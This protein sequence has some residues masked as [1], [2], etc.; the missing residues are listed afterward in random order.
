MLLSSGRW[1]GQWSIGSVSNPGGTVW[2]HVWGSESPD[3]APVSTVKGNDMGYVKDAG[4]A[5]CYPEV[6]HTPKIEKFIRELGQDRKPVFLSEYGV[7]SM[8]DVIGEWHHF[9]QAGVRPDLEDNAWVKRQSEALAADWKR[10]GFDDV[11]PFPEDLLRESQRLTARQR[12]LGFDLIRSNPDLCGFNLT[13]MLDHG[14]C[15][16]GLWTLWREWKPSTFDAVSDGWS[17]LRWCLFANPMNAYTG[18]KLTLE[19]VLA[20]EEV[21]KPGEY[22]ARFRLFG[23]AGPVWEKSA[24]V[25]IPESDPLAIPVIRETFQLEGPPGR[26]TFAADLESGAPTGGRLEFQ[27]TDPVALPKLAGSAVAWGLDVS[28]QEWLG[29]RGLTIQPLA[30]TVPADAQ[31]ILVGTPTNA[32]DPK[33][34]E[35]L[36][37]RMTGGATV[38]FLRP[39]LFLENKQAMAW[40]PLKNPGRCYTFA[41]WMYHKE[42]V[43]RRHPV[44][45]GLQGPGIMDMDYYGPVIPHEVFEGIDTPDDTM[46]AA[47]ASGYYALPGGYGSSILMGAWKSGQG[48][49]ILSTPYILENLDAHP[50]ADRLL[51]NLINYAQNKP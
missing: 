33:I 14:M 6:P 16:E 50:A 15:G 5:H 32:A 17:P 11:Y 37:K 10:L 25:T 20:N 36:K 27:V 28:A 34:W 30:A 42:C 40:L 24:V 23:P 21:L 45:E 26:Y 2:E 43:A 31:V 1:D 22:P 4:D 12:T 29:A 19:A 38:L 7:G 44:F 47:F 41:D 35:D 9:E 13:G 18:R 51:V 48:R 49:F 39:K 46:A 3:A 8:F